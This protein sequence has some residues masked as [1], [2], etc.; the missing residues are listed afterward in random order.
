MKNICDKPAEMKVAL[1]HKFLPMDYMGFEFV[2]WHEKDLT[3]AVNTF[4]IRHLHNQKTDSYQLKMYPCPN[5][6]Y[7]DLETDEDII[8]GDKYYFAKGKEYN[9]VILLVQKDIYDEN[10]KIYPKKY[11]NNINFEELISSQAEHVYQ[12]EARKSA[13]KRYD[14]D[15]EIVR[16]AV[17]RI[18]LK[19]K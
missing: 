2:V 5:I 4:W 10:D 15:V 13:E 1:C 17:A 3:C 14:F 18:M 19:R 16:Y 8:I 12:P 11:I 6:K 9:S 7:R